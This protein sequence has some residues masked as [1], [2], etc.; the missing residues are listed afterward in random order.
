MSVE[1]IKELLALMAKNELVE[2]ELEEGEFRVKLV[3]SR[4]PAAAVA[5]APVAMVAHHAGS[6][7]A[8][9]APAG[10]APAKSAAPARREGMKEIT[11]PI[12]GTFYRAPKPDADPFV[13]VGSRV[14][15]DTT[16]CI[17]E[18]MKVMNEVK[19]EIK[20]VIREILIENGQPVE[21]GQPIFVVEP[22]QA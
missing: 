18:A 2:L 13:D 5:A 3:K 12:V 19:A 10:A 22:D 9:A 8:A 16:V 7:P 6:G 11:S 14:E 17:I 21:Y 1:R 20:G 15:P 4:P